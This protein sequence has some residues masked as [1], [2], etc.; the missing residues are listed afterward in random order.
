[1]LTCTFY[2]AAPSDHGISPN[3]VRSQP[4][5][6]VGYVVG[7]NFERLRAHHH[8]LRAPLPAAF[9]PGS[10]S[11]IYGAYALLK[12]RDITSL[13]VQHEDPGLAALCLG[14]WSGARV[15]LT[16]ST[17]PAQAAGAAVAETALRLG[18]APRGE[19][20]PNSRRPVAPCLECLAQSAAVAELHTKF[21][22]VIVA[23][24]GDEC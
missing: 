21:V 7:S 9:P 1:M 2:R 12:L 14:G 3:E 22:E 5:A 19:G 18:V 16:R 13:Y 11:V 23:E 6:P 24:L 10:R 8:P 17:S 15:S 20:V 4:A